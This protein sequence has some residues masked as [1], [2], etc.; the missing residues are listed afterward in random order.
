[1]SKCGSG[2]GSTRTSLHKWEY[3]RS[4]LLQ[5][6][7][8]RRV[9]KMGRQA[10]RL[11]EEGRLQYL[12]QH[13]F[14]A[15]LVRYCETDVTSDNLAIIAWRRRPQEGESHDVGSALRCWPCSTHAASMTQEKYALKPEGKRSY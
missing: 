12:R 15:R 6:L 7:G 4:P 5:L 2:S 8:F 1:M 11:F 3:K 9:Q 10:R 14:D 13:G